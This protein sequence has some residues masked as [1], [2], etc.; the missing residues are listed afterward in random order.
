MRAALFTLTAIMAI[1]V[2][3]CIR[4]DLPDPE[5]EIEGLYEP[6]HRTTISLNMEIP[7]MDIATRADMAQGAD[8]KLNSLWVG[9]FSAKTGQCTYANLISNMVQE[10]EE[11]VDLTSDM[12]HG[13]NGVG[14]DASMNT[15]ANPAVDNNIG[16]SINAGDVIFGTAGGSVPGGNY[17]DVT[18]YLEIRIQGTPGMTVRM[19]INRQSMRDSGA[20]DFTE[21][22]VQLGTDGTGVIDISD[23]PYVHINSIKVPWDNSTNVTVT[24]I[25]LYKKTEGASL[26]KEHGNGTDYLTLND[27]ETVSGPSYIVAVGNPVGNYGSLYNRSG[28]VR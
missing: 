24:S 4:E 14:P 21:K 9:I 22:S 15:N 11:L 12:F 3:S 18:G 8:S 13:W 26:S 23:L 17:A 20:N 2:S 1:A 28:G 10:T 7:E 27:I 5:G 25:K 6:G 19:I 16:K